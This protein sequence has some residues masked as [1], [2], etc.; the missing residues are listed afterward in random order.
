MKFTLPTTIQLK[1][2]GKGE[3]LRRPHLPKPN[4]VGGDGELGGGNRGGAGGNSG[5]G[6]DPAGQQPAGHHCSPGWRRRRPGAAAG[7]GDRRAEQRQVQ[8]AG[9][10]RWPRLPPAGARHLHAA[11]ARAP[12]R[13]PLGRRGVGGIPPRPRPPVP[14]L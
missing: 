2:R 7:G 1:K 13:A 3:T 9:G 12:A 4:S 10:A 6:G 14:R 11:S 5:S 8:C